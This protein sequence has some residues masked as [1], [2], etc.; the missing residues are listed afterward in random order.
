MRPTLCKTSISSVPVR[1]A[2][3][4]APVRLAPILCAG[5]LSAAALLCGCDA[6]VEHYPPN[7]VYSLVVSAKLD[8]PT[9]LAAEDTTAALE[10]WFG[11]PIEPRW[12]ADQM[13]RDA[14]KSLVR[15]ENLQRAAGPVY[16]D[17]ENRHFGLFNEHC[18]TCHGVSGGGNG[19]A[20][21]LQNPYPRDFRP[22]VY[23]WKSTERG[24][25]PTREDLMTILRHGAPGTAM[26]SFQRLSESDLEALVDYVI[27]LS[28]RG[29]FERRL[30]TEAVVELGYEESR[31][32]D[33]ASLLTLADFDQDAFAMEVARDTLDRITG[34][35]VDAPQAVI[36]VPKETPD[37]AASIARGD[38]LYHGPIANCVGCHGKQGGGEIVTF[39]FDDWTKEFTEGIAVTPTDREAVRP[40]RKAGALRPRQI[41]PRKLTDGVYRGGG[42]P[43]TLYRRIVAG[44]AGTPMAGRSVSDQPSDKELTSDQVWDI[45]HYVRSLDEAKP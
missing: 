18:V 22:G 17:Q 45:V 20:S 5:F 30:L 7:Q 9:E 37:D 35:W 12:P 39:D 32:D 19:P 33:D 36:A 15:L 16:S 44:I 23:K 3:V 14:A 26:P 4:F 31:P 43:Q 29:E 8:A 10:A 40:F 42:D 38:E 27:Y 24:A 6:P 25:K 13:S 34:Q 2:P 1:S 21:L 11:T 28:V 41:H